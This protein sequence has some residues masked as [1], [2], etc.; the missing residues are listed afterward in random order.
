MN[1]DLLIISM[2][3]IHWESVR[4]IYQQGIDTGMATLETE[5]GTWEKWDQ[6]HLKKPR[7]IAM[8]NEQVSGWA[9]LSPVSARRV[10][11]GVAEVS[12]YIGSEFRGRGIGNRLL[13]EIMKLSEKYGFWTL[14]AGILSEN[15]P[16]IRLH[17]KNG[18]RVVGVREKLG[19]LHGTWKDIVLMERRSTTTGIN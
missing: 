15:M 12:V 7:L 10:Y 6:S 9:A 11:G 3:D 1:E 19:K 14:Q 2:Q 13:N 5:P 18:F 17:E 8:A 16:S 4:N